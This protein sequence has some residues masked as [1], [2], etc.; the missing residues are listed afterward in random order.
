[1]T[2]PET[3]THDIDALK[4]ALTAERATRPQAEVRASSAEATVAHYKRLIA[5]LKRERYGQSFEHSRRL[6]DQLELQL[7]E[8]ASSA[9]EVKAAAEP[10]DGTAVHSFTRKNRVRSP[11]PTYPL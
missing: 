9:A 10:V 2:T 7:E 8:L 3:P 4:A 5:K 11:F 6:L 1:V